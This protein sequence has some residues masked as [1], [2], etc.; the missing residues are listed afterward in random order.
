VLWRAAILNEAAPIN[1]HVRLARFY[2]ILAAILWSLAGVFIKFLSLPPLS[3]VFYRS[4][5]AAIFFVFFIRK[6]V[7]IRRGVLLLSVISYTA[8][9][10]SFVSA[11]RLTT[12]ANAII[13][14]YTAPI[15]VFIIVHF[16]F[17]ERIGRAS[18][19]ALSMGMTGIAV[20]FAGSA[21][22]PDFVGVILAL[23]SGVLFATYMLSV[24]L[25]T[26]V[27]AGTLT[28]LNNLA[29][30]V[31]LLPFVID[32]LSLSA[33]EGTLL[34]VMGV[35]Q[36]GIPYWLFSKSLDTVSI[37]EASLIVLIEPVL[38]PIWVALAVGEVPSAITL[39]GGGL[40]IAGLAVRYGW[41]M[42]T[43]KPS[44]NHP[45]HPI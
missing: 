34:A 26:Q 4:F 24:R 13:L 22:K 32:Q 43:A 31:I 39:I 6:S 19:I 18:W 14:Q 28:F 37:H 21:G 27:N 23:S 11:N 17:R 35:V 20:I 36:L 1:L 2:L 10:S 25:L 33:S 8:A 38:N 42:M 3:L 29:C 30:C 45:A 12:A 9:I 44:R 16:L 41:A 15:F 5:F 40:I 7:A